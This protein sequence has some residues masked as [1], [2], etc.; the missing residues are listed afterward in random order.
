[1]RRRNF[2]RRRDAS[3]SNEGV[4]TYSKVG[5]PKH[6]LTYIGIVQASNVAHKCAAEISIDEEMRA[7]QTKV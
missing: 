5:E 2:D 6:I 7:S 3:E 4:V 1:M